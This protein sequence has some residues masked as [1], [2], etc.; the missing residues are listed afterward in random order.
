MTWHDARCGSASDRLSETIRNAHNMMHEW[1]RLQNA[2]GQSASLSN[3][4]LRAQGFHVLHHV[5]P[6]LI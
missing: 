5:L 2:E 6:R 3:L 4:R 1:G